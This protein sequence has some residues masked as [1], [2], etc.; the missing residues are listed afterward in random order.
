MATEIPPHNLRE[1][2]EAT[3]HLIRHPE[4]T[5]DDVLAM[6][7]GPDFP[8][9]GQLISTPQTIPR[10]LRDR[11][12]QPAPARAL[13]DRGPRAR[14]VARHRR[15]TAARR[16]RRTGAVRDRDLTNPQPRA[17]KKEV[18]KSRRTSGS[19]CSA[20]STRYATSPAT[21]R[22]CASCS[23]QVEPAEPRRVHG[24]A[25]RPHQPGDLGPVNMTMI[26]RDGRPQQKNLV[27]ILREWI[28][29]RY[30]TVERRTRHRLDEVDRPHPH[31]RRP[32]DRL[33]AGH[34]GS[35]RVIRESDEPKP[36]LIAAF[37]LSDVQAEDILEIRLRQL[38]RLEGF[39][40]EKELAELKDERGTAA[41][42]RQPRGD[43]EADPE[44]RSRTTPR[45]TAMTAARWSRPWPVAPAG[46]LGTGR[47]GHRDR[48][49][50]AGCARARATASTRPASPTR[51]AISASRCSKRAPP[52]R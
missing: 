35:D 11:P 43:D 13:E 31:P 41:P 46:D 34:R 10:G 32:H 51:L 25:A 23:S 9:G 16:V 52:G 36:A 4:A 48:V 20:R 17:G 42:P 47:A 29:F 22:R 33:P 3:C 24:G 15:R 27:Q 19:S 45:S 21:R 30:V 50:N 7:P 40:I 38:A 8:G 26:G 28:A 6:L 39:K 44:G 1:V 12:R 18:S 37:G 5:L 14:P 49:E 2:A